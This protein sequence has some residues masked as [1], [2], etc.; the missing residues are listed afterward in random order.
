MF[1]EP[2]TSITLLIFAII[3]AGVPAESSERTII[4]YASP[5][6]VRPGETV[7]FKVNSGEGVVDMSERSGVVS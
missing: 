4:G 2:R 6:T 5:V 1:Q 7:E 3:F